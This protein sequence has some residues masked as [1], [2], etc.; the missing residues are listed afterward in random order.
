MPLVYHVVSDHHVPHIA[1]LHG[2]KTVAQF[3]SDIDFLTANLNPV[4]PNDL[5]AILDG[6]KAIKTPSFLLT[7]DDG[8]REIRDIIAPILVSKGI[9]AILFVN[10]DFVDNN[11]LFFRHKASLLVDRCRIDGNARSGVSG[12]MG[13]YIEGVPPEQAVLCVTHEN[14]HWLDEAA[15]A[16]GLDFRA[17]LTTRRPYLTT[18][19]LR[20]LVGQ[21]F[22][23]GAHSRSHP[24]YGRLSEA[25]QWEET[26]TSL[27]FVRGN[28]G[29]ENIF[30]AFPFHDLDV[31]ASVFA[32]M[33]T[34][35]VQ[36]SFGTQ[37]FRSD[38]QARNIQ[39]LFADM[40]NI[41]LERLIV[42]KC[43]ELLI[44]RL[45]K[46]DKIVRR[47]VGPCRSVAA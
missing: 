19:E 38:G 34:F 23:L 32:R 10:S 33:E 6:R 4:D 18:D 45:I 14:E 30:F 1:H 16:I 13:K 22:T 27:E 41:S 31:P 28:F 11:K 9:P 39:R 2:Y 40:P 36:V 20:D 42:R 25:A 35:G 21:G 37:A 15:D 17:F 47:Q 29:P 43:G 26:R 46:K 12:I 7:F 44:L 24:H 5:P 3:R 8:L